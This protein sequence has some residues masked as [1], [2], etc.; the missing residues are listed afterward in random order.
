ML[1]NIGLIIVSI[2]LLVLLYFFFM[3]SPIVGLESHY[4]SLMS[5]TAMFGVISAI[6]GTVIYLNYL[7]YNKEHYSS[8]S[9]YY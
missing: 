1:A 7:D 4:P 8:Y 2:V 5:R 6:F 9:N 3:G